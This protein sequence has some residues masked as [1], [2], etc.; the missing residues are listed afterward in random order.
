MKKE[1]YTIILFYKFFKIKN[2][3]AFKLKQK[4]IAEKFNLKGRMLIGSEGVNGTLEGTT[5]NVKAYIK[6]LRKQNVFKDMVFKD[7][8]GTGTGF[9]KLKIKTR[10]EIVTLG[11]SGF[12][13]KKET[14]KTVTADQLEKMYKNKEDFVVLDLRNDFEVKVGY[15]ENTVDPELVNFRDLP[16]KLPKLRK[17]LRG[18]KVVTV[19]TGGIRCEK[20]T[21]LMK[22]EGFENLYQLKDGIY[23]Y[24]KK[25]PNKHFKG[26][27]FTFDNRMTT[28]V[29]EVKAREIIGRCIYCSK[30]CEQFASDD[31]LRPSRKVISAPSVSASTLLLTATSA[32]ALPIKSN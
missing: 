2:L 21:C 13:V 18:K 14:A 11:I 31:S 12:N 5:K 32:A 10:P 3:E 28:P 29:A 20:A 17:A 22:Q 26:T 15:F 4:K 9:T 6:E 24:M 25:Y 19:C 7:S 30:K 16:G 27:L 23:S 8:E 1:S